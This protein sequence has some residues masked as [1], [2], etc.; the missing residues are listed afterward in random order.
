MITLDMIPIQNHVVVDRIVNNEAV[1]VLPTKG[2]V[3]VLNEVGARIWSSV[4]GTRTV[5]EI[6]KI[7]QTE[8]AVSAQDAREDT[9]VFLGQLADRDI[10]TFSS[11]APIIRK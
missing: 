7:I 3:K 11:G 4:D 9:C 5:G 6:I 2:Q 10:I 1:L 8:Y